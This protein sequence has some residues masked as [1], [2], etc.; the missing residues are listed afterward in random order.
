MHLDERFE[1]D[2]KVILLH[3]L[4]DLFCLLS[5]Q[6]HNRIALRFTF[7]HHLRIEFSTPSSL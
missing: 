5:K 7:E 3:Y 4:I 1:G 6:E 2:Q